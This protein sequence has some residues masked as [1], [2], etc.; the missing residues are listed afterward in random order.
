MK[1]ALQI[2]DLRAKCSVSDGAV[3]RGSNK[4]RFY[5]FRDRFAQLSISDPGGHLLG[6]ANLLGRSLG[7]SRRLRLRDLVG[8]RPGDE[9]E[10]RP[11]RQPRRDLAR[12]VGEL[13]AP[14]R[15]AHMDDERP[16][17]L[18]TGRPGIARDLRADRREPAVRRVRSGAALGAEP[19]QL[20]ADLAAD[21]IHH[22]ASAI[23][24]GVTASSWSG[25]AGSIAASVAVTSA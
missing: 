19:P 22:A 8:Q 13:E 18:E 3:G 12:A 20:L 15:V 1:K 14:D 16:V 10:S 6:L 24:P 2:A 7:R 17:G 23:A 11:A 25:A 5:D 9:A 21:R 4:R